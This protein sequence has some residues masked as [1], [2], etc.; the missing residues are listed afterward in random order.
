M[1]ITSDKEKGLSVAI[2]Q[3]DDGTSEVVVHTMN[4]TMW[5]TQPEIAEAFGVKQ[6]NVSTHISNIF[7]EGEVKEEGN[8]DK[9]KNGFDKPT[10]VYSLDVIISVGYRVNSMKATHFR[11]W[12]TEHLKSL[13]TKG[14]SIDDKVLVAG[15]GLQELY[16]KIRSLRT[17]EVNMYQKVRDV[18]KDSSS[19][20]DSTSKAARHFFAVAQDKF[21]Y[22]VTEQ[23]AAEIILDRADG[24]KKEVG[25]VA[26]K[27]EH[28]P[29]L[30]D[31]KTA[32][33]YLK[34]EELR[35]LEN[36][37]EQFLLFAESKAFRG[38]KMTM[39]QI[40]HKLNTLLEA[41]DYPVLWEYDSFKRGQA[42]AHA[43]AQ[44]DKY[45]LRLKEGEKGAE[46]MKIDKTKEVIM[47]LTHAEPPAEA[48]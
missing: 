34:P 33:N 29:Q 7:S 40:S 28:A 41:N 32:K 17:S 48:A 23:T 16:E 43:K 11:Q 9:I 36:I 19:D 22:A 2:Y 35:L 37:S 24:T 31:V 20:Y 45:R 44:L 47:S 25:M 42:D 5:A 6:S 26:Y 4:G 3:S 46:L 21:H 18:F 10:N 39:E 8:I 1:T 12:A 13:A 14:Y 30:Q 38:Q 27:A 15:G